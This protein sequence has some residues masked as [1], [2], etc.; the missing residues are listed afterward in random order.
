MATFDSFIRL[1]DNLSKSTA[2]LVRVILM[3]RRTDFPRLQ[4]C[5]GDALIILGNGPSLRDNL[6]QDMAV[7]HSHDTL[8]VN[9]AATTPEFKSLHPRYY[10]LAD[11]HFFNNTEDANVSRLIESL[12]AV[13][14]GLIL[15]VPAQSARKVRRMISNPNIRIA[16]FNMLAAEGFLWLS[17]QLMQRHMGMPRPRNVLIPSLM[18]GIWLGYSRIVVLGADHSWLKTLSVDDN[19][20][21]VSVQPHFYKENPQEIERI[22][23]TY[24]S[25][26]LH[27]V[28]ESMCIAFKAYHSIEAFA[29]HRGVEILN[30]TPGS[31]ID[32]FRR[33]NLQAALTD[34]KT[35]TNRK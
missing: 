24:D 2:T 16:G 5:R 12:S 30:A 19:N 1:I 14:W 35:L 10:V 29:R 23:K 18:I 20:K 8:A 34:G 21:V 32:A 25:R 28:L 31:Y 26:R 6:D 17:Q 15:F 4:T 11:P 33:A 7:L 27:E 13:D 9:F 22:T 3:G